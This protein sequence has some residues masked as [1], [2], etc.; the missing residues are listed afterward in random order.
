MVFRKRNTHIHFVGVGGIGMT[1]IAEVLLN[2]GYQVSGSDLQRERDHASGSPAWAPRHRH[3]HAADER[4]RLRRGRHLVRHH[5]PAT[6]R[7]TRPARASIPVIP[8]AEM[9]AE[10][11]RMKYGI[12]VAGS[13]GKTTTTSL[14]A[15]VLDAAGLDPTVGHRRQAAALGSNARLGQGEY[16]VAEA[17]ESDGSF[18]Q[19]SPTVAVVT[20]IDPEHLDHYGDLETLKRAFVDFVNKS[21]L[22][23][24]RGPVPRPP[25]RAARSCRAIEQ[26]PRHLRALAR[27]PTGAPTTSAFDGPAHALR[28]RTTAQHA[29]GRGHGGHA[30]P[31]QRAERAGDARGRG[32]PR[33]PVRRTTRARWRPSRACSAASP[34]AARPAG[35]MVVD[36][37]GHHPAEIRATLAAAAR[38]LGPPR[39]GRVPAAPLH[40]HARSAR[41]VRARPSTTPTVVLRA[42]I[43]AAG[44]DAI[45]GVTAARLVERMRAHGHKHVVHV[46][47]ARGAI[48]ALLAAVQPGDVVI[49]LGAGDVRQADE[50]LAKLR[51][52][53]LTD[54]DR[55]ALRAA[56]RGEVRFDE[57]MAR[58]TTLRIGGPVDAL[59]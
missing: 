27:R 11:M 53:S 49:T 50:L 54:A 46:G 22:L 45:P 59:R 19:L 12:A 41:R 26:A 9:L 52:S 3:G 44:E 32:L 36:D 30:R 47:G 18:L 25:E 4:G 48:P 8:R 23:R 17:D 5:G 34:S 2:L 15:T 39:G 43:Y 55:A 28:R 29:P 51:A 7:W 42:D 14:M 13:H 35:V 31:A 1:G 21:A 40:A 33:D 56:V 57:P 10:L 58:H 6:P 38:L 16:L 20:N 24:A 37:Y